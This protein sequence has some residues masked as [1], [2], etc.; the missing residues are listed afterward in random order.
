MCGELA[1]ERVRRD[2]VDERLLAG[3]LDDRD[4]L[5]VALLELPGGRDV[6]LTQP[7]AELVTQLLERRSGALAQVAPGR[8]V[9]DDVC[10]YG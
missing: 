8:V 7:E 5:A 2:V 4:Q 1:T 10:R 3:D 6:D 9:E